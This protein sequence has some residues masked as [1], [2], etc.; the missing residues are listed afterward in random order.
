MTEDPQ[1]P[2]GIVIS[3]GDVQIG[4]VAQGHK[5]RASY[6]QV[7]EP[8]Q[9]RPSDAERDELAALLLELHRA[10]QLRE[11][12][13]ADPPAVNAAIEEVSAELGKERPERSRVR[14]ALAR[15][16]ATAGPAVEIA[17]AAATLGRAIAG[18]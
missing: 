4:A 12:E 6:R 16:A 13:L 9:W 14:S 2:A 10:V 7:S 8:A 3:G 1:P 15:I 17:A 18:A 11:A 5:A